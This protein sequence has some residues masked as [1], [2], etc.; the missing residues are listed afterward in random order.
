MLILDLSRLRDAAVDLESLHICYI[1]EVLGVLE[2]QF[3]IKCVGTVGCETRIV[4]H[5]LEY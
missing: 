3:F 1:V 5:L 4:V 2:E